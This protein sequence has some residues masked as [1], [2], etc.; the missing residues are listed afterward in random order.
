MLRIKKT[1]GPLSDSCA[2]ILA[3]TLR[4]DYLNARVI[5]TWPRQAH[6]PMPA[7]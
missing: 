2:D 3:A 5:A 4:V 7:R 1:Y 6:N